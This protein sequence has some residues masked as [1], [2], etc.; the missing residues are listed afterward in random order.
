[1]SFYTKDLYSSFYFPKKDLNPYTYLLLFKKSGSFVE[2][3]DFFQKILKTFPESYLIQDILETESLLLK[4][5]PRFIL[6]FGS[7]ALKFFR[8]DLSLQK[9][10]GS[11]QQHPLGFEFYPLFHPDVLLLN[12][13]LKK[14]FW[15]DLQHLFS[16]LPSYNKR[17]SL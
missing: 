11:F 4:N 17:K 1:M 3:E 15:K 5:Q 14:I 8:P 16:L 9:V 2:K 6:T 10:H 7:E 13:D 12:E